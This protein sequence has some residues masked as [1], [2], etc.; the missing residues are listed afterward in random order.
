[1]DNCMVAVAAG[2]CE[3]WITGSCGRRH[4]YVMDNCKVTV[5]A[6]RGY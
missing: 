1:M 6:G 4:R 3:L 5:A 2:S